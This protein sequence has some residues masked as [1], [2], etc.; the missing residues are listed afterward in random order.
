[1]GTDLKNKLPDLTSD[2]KMLA[3]LAHLSIVLGGIILA[4]IL[5]ATQKDK[6]KFVRFNSLQA[7]FY[8]IAY[9]VI[10]V[11]F[12]IL[13]A[14][15][16]IISGVGFGMFKEANNNNMP[17]AMIITLI[18]FYAGLFI[19]IIAGIAYAIYVAVKS[20]Q[21]YLIKIPIIGNIIYKKVYG[22]S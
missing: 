21:G 2:E 16:M 15:V 3:M 18:L 20:Y 1:M 9:A 10:I 5:W 17:V 4:I 6:S 8:H 22:E 14:L 13:F 11:A 19:I 12:V 7:I